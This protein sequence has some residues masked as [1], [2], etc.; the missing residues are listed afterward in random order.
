MRP[1]RAM[2]AALVL[3][4]AGCG[5]AARQ[6]D[7]EGPVNGAHE[8][9]PPKSVN[10][11]EVS[12]ML[13]RELG[14]LSPGAHWGTTRVWLNIDAEGIVR[15]VEIAEGSGNAELDAIVLR[16]VRHLRYEPARRDGRPV[17]ARIPHS[18][19]LLGEAVPTLA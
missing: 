17:E 5:T 11:N 19:T 12:R 8:D 3:L 7:P 6:G 18:V 15:S 14:R 16:V 2:V 4:A 1:K 13:E 10:D 9:G